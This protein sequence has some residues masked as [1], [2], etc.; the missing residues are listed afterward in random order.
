LAKLQAWAKFLSPGFYLAPLTP[1]KAKSLRRL[2]RLVLLSPRPRAL[3]LGLLV[4]LA[5]I[6]VLLAALNARRVVF[7]L[8]AIVIN[9]GA[10]T[11]L[12]LARTVLGLQFIAMPFNIAVYHNPGTADRMTRRGRATR[13]HHRDSNSRDNSSRNTTVHFYS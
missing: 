9:L 3:L 2:L 5:V 8:L 4:A 7:A 6:A 10:H 12:V 11:K 1:L 13:S